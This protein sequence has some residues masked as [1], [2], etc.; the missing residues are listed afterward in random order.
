MEFNCVC[1]Y[2]TRVLMVVCLMVAPSHNKAVESDS[3]PSYIRRLA[4]LAV[5]QENIDKRLGDS[6]LLIESGNSNS[7]SIKKRMKGSM[8]AASKSVAHLMIQYKG[9]TYQCSG[10]L[11]KA[12]MVLTAAWCA[13]KKNSAGNEPDIDPDQLK[14]TFLNPKD[15]SFHGGLRTR[16][17]IS[18]EKLS[19]T[20][21]RHSPGYNYWTLGSDI[22]SFT[23]SR[24]MSTAGGNINV[25]QI[26][27][28]APK[29][30][31]KYYFFGYEVDSG[32]Q[33][34]ADAPPP[35][36]SKDLSYIPMVLLDNG[37][38]N[39]ILQQNNYSKLEGHAQSACFQ[40]NV[41]NN[42]VKNGTNG[43]D[44]S[45]VCGFSDIGGGIYRGNDPN[46]AKS[47]V[48]A[49]VNVGLGCRG[50]VTFGTRID[51]LYKQILGFTNPQHG[52]DDIKDW[53]KQIN[54]SGGVGGENG[55][56]GNETGESG[57]PGQPTNMGL[58]FSLTICVVLAGY[59]LELN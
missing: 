31:D 56:Y 45:T 39:A 44:T 43:T 1:V 7:L 41:N 59:A 35:G 25:A 8:A 19:A 55:D 4:S 36:A 13:A 38:C 24:N 22:A 10:T 51:G 17:G 18:K 5:S 33:N 16:N 30:G 49:V 21:L 12:D 6:R 29:I 48:F 20:K 11:I 2:V 32:R 23:L 52:K 27:P 37:R 42:N 54:E 34:L 46:D 26:C 40:S 50:R 58:L 57:A 28:D 15:F 53:S 3:P 9:D 14:A 47:C